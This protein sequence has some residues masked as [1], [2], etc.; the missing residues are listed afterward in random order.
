M[1]RLGPLI[2][3]RYQDGKIVLAHKSEQFVPVLLYKEFWRVQG[4]SI[5][6]PKT[7]VVPI[8]K[9]LTGVLTPFQS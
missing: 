9:I 2:F 5:A 7:S 4:F 1:G 8:R 6:T 3:G